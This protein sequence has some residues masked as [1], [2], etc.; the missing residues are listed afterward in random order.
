[1]RTFFLI[2][3]AVLLMSGLLKMQHRVSSRVAWL[4]NEWFVEPNGD[5]ITFTA[6]GM[7]CQKVTVNADAAI[8]PRLETSIIGGRLHQQFVAQGFTM[9]DGKKLSH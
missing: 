9:V 4:S 3:L 6:T 7:L 2:A 5:S 8:K 1:M